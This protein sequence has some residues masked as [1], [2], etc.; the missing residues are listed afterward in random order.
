MAKRRKFKVAQI[1]IDSYEYLE[2]IAKLE[3][4]AKGGAVKPSW[5]DILHRLIGK[6]MGE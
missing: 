3:R 1:K 4:M 2:D 5:V 6:A